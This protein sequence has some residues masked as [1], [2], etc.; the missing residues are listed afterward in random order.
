MNPAP[1]SFVQ[2]IG[3]CMEMAGHRDGRVAS[4]SKGEIHASMCTSEGQT[5]IKCRTITNSNVIWDQLW[6]NN[7]A[8][9]VANVKVDQFM[10]MVVCELEAKRKKN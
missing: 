8:R 3:H 4:R 5:D 10:K 9:L 6:L 1:A 2:K 7:D